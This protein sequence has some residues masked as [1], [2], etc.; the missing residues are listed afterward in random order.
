[1]YIGTAIAMIAIG[2]ILAFAVEFEVAGINIDVVGWI[3]MIVG[4]IGAVL[5][6]TV[7][8]PRTRTTGGTR[9]VVRERDR[10]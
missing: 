6:L 4:A 9:E 5:A 10:Y 8:G 3:L 2:A 7:W 1:M